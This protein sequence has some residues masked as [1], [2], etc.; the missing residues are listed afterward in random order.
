MKKLLSAL[1]VLMFMLS[2]V[3]MTATA[4]TEGGTVRMLVNVT[5][6][7]DEEENVLWAQALGEA[8]GLTIE[9]EKPASD[10]QGD[11]RRQQRDAR[12]RSDDFGYGWFHGFSLPI[13][14]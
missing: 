13:S 1:L 3:A 6:G 5:G 12:S 11:A 14:R 8:T 10:Y 7:K 9:L 2:A 4:E